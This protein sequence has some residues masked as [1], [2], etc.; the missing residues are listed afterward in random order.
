M[1]SEKT[2]SHLPIP[3]REIETQRK[4]VESFLTNVEWPPRVQLA[5][6]VGTQKEFQAGTKAWRPAVATGA[7]RKEEVSLFAAG[8]KLSG[9]AALLS[10]DVNLV[11]L[12]VR[13]ALCIG[14][15]LGQQ[16]F[17]NAGG[18]ELKAVCDSQQASAA[19]KAEF[20]QKQNTTAA[21]TVFVAASYISWKLG[22]YKQEQIASLQLPFV[23]VPEVD[24]TTPSAAVRCFLFYLG[25]YLDP[26]RAK[27]VQNGTAMVK[28]ALLYSD[29][30]LKELRSR[31]ASLRYTEPFTQVSYRY[32]DTDFVVDGFEEVTSVH[33][34]SVEFKRVSFNEIVGNQVAKDAAN[35]LASRLACFDPV[36]KANPFN[37]LGGFHSVVMGYGKAG[38]GKT[39]INAATA[40]KCHELCILV[41]LPFVCWPLPDNIVSTFQGGSAERMMNWIR[42]FLDTDKIIFGPV[43]DAENS[44]E[45]R[46]RQN[47]SA[48]VREVI[49]VFLRGTEGASAIWHGNSVISFYTNLPEQLD[50]AVISRVQARYPIEGAVTEHDFLDQ[51]YLWWKKLADID[52]RFVEMKKPTDYEYMS[53]QAL[54]HSLSNS[55]QPVLSLTDER[56]RNV[57]ERV[58]GVHQTTDHAFYGALYRGVMEIYPSFSSRDVRNI[59][60]AVQ[61]RV[62]DFDLPEVW[63]EKPDD[64]YRQDYDR[65]VE[66]LKDLMRENMRTISFADIRH[67]ETLR[68]LN[69]MAAILN[70][71]RERKI[72][73]LLEEMDIREEAMRRKTQSAQ[74]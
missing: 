20:S 30:V 36:R 51:D 54:L 72:A 52:P 49:G 4:G 67:E 53:D 42:R 59:Q 38:T 37:E 10:E 45:E 19:Q 9:G 58:S 7:P 18:F 65:K 22:S 70:A 56:M 71:D 32:D 74:A 55:S 41:G 73:Q 31:V 35:R 26:E 33:G 44:F 29:A 66:M 48:G 57:Y 3:E 2:G 43:D 61:S 28:M 68:Y 39:L 47:V 12:A 1:S 50:R 62:T 24:I 63:L 16:Y 27:I 25:V 17:K 23:G 14:L 15:Y 69:S 34:I 46:T 40:T 5:D 13:Q 60:S 64:F 11:L 21:V 8:K 6:I